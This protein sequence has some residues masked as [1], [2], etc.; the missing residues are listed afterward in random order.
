MKK[1]FNYTVFLLLFL[2]FIGAMGF[3]S[4]VKYHYDGGEKYQYLQKTVLFLASVP[5]HIKNVIEYRTINFNKIYNKP[6]ALSKHEDKKRFEQFIPNKRNALLVLSRYDNNISRSVV[7]IIDL[8]NFKVIH[9]YQ[10]DISEMYEQVENMEEFPRLNIDHPP[11]RFLYRHP[12]I[13]EDGSLISNSSGPQFKIDFCS[14]LKWVND[15]ETFHH[16]TNLG[17]DGNIW[18]VA[19]IKPYSKYV[20]KYQIKDFYDTAIIKMNSDGKIL[21]TKSVIEILIE[22]KIFPENYAYN[23]VYDNNPNPIHLNDIQPALSDTEYWKKGDLFLSIKN[24]SAIIHYRPS[25]NK[26]INYLTGP[27]ARQHDVDI[28]SEKEISIFNNNNFFVDNQY[29]EV[30]IYNF[31]TKKFKKLFNDQLQK[32]NFKTS[33]NGLSIILNDGALMVEE[34][35]HGRIILFNNR[36]QKEWEFINKDNQGNVAYV[37]WGR[38]IEDKLFIEKFK[39]LVENKKCIN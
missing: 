13:L 23:A 2:S 38:I 39:S 3:A 32:E 37:K 5:A 16:S 22:N 17:P 36:G 18:Q 4:V 11:I 34:Q 9:T 20:K 8:N 24:Q 21:Y 7:D 35:N 10:H 15:E 28:I 12:L 33:D 14:N 30:L 6:P 29:S 25:I 31:E 27:F 19:E 1:F 26:V